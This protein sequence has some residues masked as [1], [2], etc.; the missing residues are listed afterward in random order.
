[1]ARELAIGLSTAYRDLAHL[2]AH[3]FIASDESGKRSITQDGAEYLKS[4]LNAG[5]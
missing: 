1:M 4:L 3:G 2:E 5:A